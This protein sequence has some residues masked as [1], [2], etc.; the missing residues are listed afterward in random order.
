LAEEV[1]AQSDAQLLVFVYQTR[2]AEAL[3]EHLRPLL[4]D[5][6][7]LAGPMA[8]HA[9]LS[10]TRREEVRHSF[11]SGECR[12][13]VATTALALGVNLPATHVCVRDVL[14]PGVG[15][16]SVS[17]LLQMM[18]RAGR[19][20]RPG[21]A[22]VLVRGKEDISADELAR[23]IRE[24]ALPE[25]CSSLEPARKGRSGRKDEEPGAD[26][27]ALVLSRLA[28]H[29]DEG[30][31]APEVRDFFARSLGAQAIVGKVGSALDWLTDP[32]RVLAYENEQHRFKPTVLGLRAARAVLPLKVAAGVARLIRDLLALDEEN[33]ILGTWRP[34]DFLFVLELTYPHTGLGVRFSER[35]AARIDAWMEGQSDRAPRL[36]RG[37]MAGEGGPSRA[38][39]ILASLGVRL[40]DRKTPEGA[41]KVAYQ[42]LLR[43]IVLAERGHGAGEENLALTWG[44]DNLG[45]VEERWR[46]DHLWLLSGLRDIL[47]VRCFYYHLK[48][49]CK[50][51][52]D[53]LRRVDAA[54]HR[55]R[56]ATFELQK[57]LKDCK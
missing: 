39:Q 36:Y 41:R 25:L 56:K 22:V 53:R 31:T 14:F 13:V 24:G 43:C 27:A 8:Y 20:D 49:V 16:L 44:L 50:V 34:F 32:R 21:H 57:Q 45:G 52:A 33:E 30:L 1:L 10:Q 38:Q 15:Y 54:F 4:G 29:A 18:G 7:G 37:W 28:R 23:A 11:L 35:L 5:R 9:Q 55:M 3:A 6:A 47:E 40:E 51:D 2:A 12:L 42:A 19:G 17:D 48:E 46:D 26:C